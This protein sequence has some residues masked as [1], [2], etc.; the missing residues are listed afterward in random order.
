MNLVRKTKS[1]YYLDKIFNKVKNTEL[2][3]NL[4]YFFYLQWLYHP[5]SSCNFAIK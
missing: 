1:Q 5:W 2:K 3:I 4:L